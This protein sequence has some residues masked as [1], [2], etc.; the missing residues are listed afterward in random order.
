M[1]CYGTGCDK[2]KLPGGS[3]S[4]IVDDPRWFVNS[5]HNSSYGTVDSST[6]QEKNTNTNVTVNSVGSINS[7]KSLIDLKYDDGNT[8]HHYPYKTTMKYIPNSWL[9]YNKYNG[10]ATQ[11]EFDVEFLDDQGDWAGK[12]ET[13]TATDKN[14]SKRTTRRLIW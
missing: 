9:I 2:T 4:E 6:L 1:Y 5:D 14:A 7:G 12:Y 8:P 10:G 3:S 11:N 13:N